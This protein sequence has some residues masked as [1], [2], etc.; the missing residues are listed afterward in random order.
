M[1][2]LK[3][4]VLGVVI[5]PFWKI[6]LWA[7]NFTYG[8]VDTTQDIRDKAVSWAQTRLGRPYQLIFQGGANPY[9]NDTSDPFSDHWYCS[10]LIWAAYWNQGVK[11]I[12]DYG[13][14]SYNA[15]NVGSLLAA[16][17][18]IL[19]DN[20]ADEQ[21]VFSASDSID[22]DGEIMK[23]HWDFGDGTSGYGE[24]NYHYYS[25][26]GIYT[27]T[28][29]IKDN[30]GSYA[31]D[32]TTA[33]ISI[34]NRKPSDV[35]I[36]GNISG[37]VYDTL[38]Y[39]FVATD[40]DNNTIQY[41]IDWDDGKKDTSDYIPCGICFNTS[42]Q[43]HN[44]GHYTIYCKVTDGEYTSHASFSVNIKEKNPVYPPIPPNQ[45]GFF[46]FIIFYIIVCG[47]FLLIVIKK[48]RI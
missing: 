24:W 8:S 41:I 28:L 9:P 47:S 13:E 31:T 40:P 17:N 3:G 10:E 11:L 26:P 44:V 6:Q 48:R 43:W 21:I 16:D 29:T 7:T 22:T 12:V 46:L 15:S 30:G 23:Y 5:S 4:N 1:R 36:I 45:S 34:R 32:T 35:E 27:V 33:T 18:I 2:L 14:H 20:K 25:H 19:Y 42:H 39:S 38:M 37:Y